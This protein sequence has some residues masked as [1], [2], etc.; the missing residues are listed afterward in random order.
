M[1][2][3]FGMHSY[4]L[5]LFFVMSFPHFQFSFSRYLWKHFSLL[6]FNFQSLLSGFRFFVSFTS[7]EVSQTL[8]LLQVIRALAPTN[9]S[10]GFVL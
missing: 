4:L 2:L 6:W 5:Y 9:E 10:E 3:L 1:R 7:A 8:K